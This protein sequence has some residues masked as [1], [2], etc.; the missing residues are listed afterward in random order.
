MYKNYYIKAQITIPE[1]DHTLA[2]DNI[3]DAYRQ[4]KEYFISPIELE[5]GYEISS[6]SIKEIECV[7]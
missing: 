5:R 7:L 1:L 6:L 4:A 2:A 3:D